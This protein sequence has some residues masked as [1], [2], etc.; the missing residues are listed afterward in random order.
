MRRN[1]FNSSGAS[2]RAAC[3]RRCCR[4]RGDAGRRDTLQGVGQWLNRRRSRSARRR[5]R[6][7][8]KDAQRAVQGVAAKVLR[9][10][11][12][13]NHHLHHART[14]ADELHDLR[15]DDGRGHRHPDGQHKPHQHPAGKE[16]GVAQNSHGA[17]I[18]GGR[19][20]LS[21]SSAPKWVKTCQTCSG[22]ALIKQR[23]HPPFHHRPNAP[24]GPV[25]SP[26]P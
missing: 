3:G 24:T 6:R 9:T 8:A 21:R 18:S 14:R 5:W 13:L 25:G 12:R 1:D 7:M 17:I 26:P 2:R 23:C 4:G 15:V 11:R 16:M 20:H 22:E 10:V 19:R